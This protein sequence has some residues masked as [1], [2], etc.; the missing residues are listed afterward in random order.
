M[1]FSIVLNPAVFKTDNPFFPTVFF[2][3]S[4]FNGK[5]WNLYT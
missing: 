3:E 2:I 4:Y 1:E 5:L